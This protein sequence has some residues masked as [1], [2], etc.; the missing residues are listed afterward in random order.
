MIRPPVSLDYLDFNIN[1]I[2]QV[3]Q[4]GLP[5]ALVQMVSHIKVG[6]IAKSNLKVQAKKI[7][8][9]SPFFPWGCF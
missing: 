1:L 2:G 7:S 4:W 8:E 3:I 9:V 6:S 5:L